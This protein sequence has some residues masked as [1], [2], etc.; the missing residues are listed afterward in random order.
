MG[1]MLRHRRKMMSL[2]EMD[3]ARRELAVRGRGTKI[4]SNKGK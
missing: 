2:R 1:P 4:T 3:S